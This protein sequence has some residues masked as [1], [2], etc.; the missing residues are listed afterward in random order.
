MTSRP[1]SGAP[2]DQAQRPVFR[3]L[4]FVQVLATTVFGIVPLMLPAT[5][6]AVT[7]YSGDDELIY[8]FAGAATTGYFV[9][10]AVALTQRSAWR[11]LRIPLVATLSFTVAAALACAWTLIEGDRHA[12]VA[13]VLVAATAFALLAAY[14]LRADAGSETADVG[15][16][17]EPVWRGV[18]GIATLAAAVFGLAGLLVPG[19]LAPVVG[20]EGTDLWIFRMSG[21][22]C[23]GYAPAG[24]LSIMAPGY[25]RIRVQNLAGITFNATAA[26]ASWAALAAGEG[27]L[28]AP[29]VGVA[30]TF[31]AVALAGLDWT[32]TERD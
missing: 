1:F 32:H 11:D 5:F 14:W 25:S 10:A 6:A 24:I 27:G 13:L 19:L 21:A 2:V 7:G 16:P 15:R 29:L 23:F 8:R 28:V 20:L 30:A 31:F 12:V 9:A 22:A 3:A 4:L 26:I 18:I 17:L